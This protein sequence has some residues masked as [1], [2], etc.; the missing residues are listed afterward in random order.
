MARRDQ[1]RE[2]RSLQASGAPAASLTIMRTDTVFAKLPIH[3]L[4]KAAPIHIEIIKTNAQG[5]RE[6]YWQVSSSAAYGAP[7]LLAYKLDTLVI[8]RYL[9][10]L[11]RPLPTLIRLA[12][13]RAICQELGLGTGKSIADVK[14]AF[15]QNAGAYITAKVRY[16]GHDGK[17]RRLEAGFTRYAVVFTGESLPDGSAADAV[18]IVLSEPYRHVLNAAPTRP[19]DYDYL[20]GLKPLAQRFYELL[21][22]RMFAALKHG[23]PEVAMRYSEFCLYAP[24]HRHLDGAQMSKQMHKVHQPHLASGYLAAAQTERV[25]DDQGAPDWLLRYTPGPK[26]WAEYQSFTGPGRHGETSLT[27]PAGVEPSA[28]VLS[29]AAETASIEPMQAGVRTDR[30]MTAPS[31]RKRDARA[32]IKLNESAASGDPFG[33]ASDRTSFPEGQTAPA[34]TLVQQFYR[35]VHGVADKPPHPQELAHASG[36][37]QR[38]GSEFAAFFLNYA[39]RAM[40]QEDR[41]AHVFGGL[42]RYEASALAAYRR[43]AAQTAAQQAESGAQQR[44][45]RLDAYEAWLRLQLDALKETLPPEEL[46]ALREQAW[47]QARSHQQVPSYLLTRQVEH[48]VETQLIQMHGLPSFE[49]W[50]AHDE[51]AATPS[52]A[53]QERAPSGR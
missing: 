44:R 45:R 47:R 11:E 37:L 3:Q 6:L 41:M 28:E 2:V 48:E 21:S 46:E 17:Q 49:V 32:K 15:H 19:V 24:Q 22:F 8:N 42:M 14:R 18:Y 29:D 1:L 7:Q 36:L 20:S 51:M 5:I 34:A 38:Y 43:Q 9:E 10:A 50:S 27:T 26:A 30:P 31:S 16:R 23:R 39:K 52:S 12:S 25:R 35:D 33:D 13:M 4:A 40:R 53:T